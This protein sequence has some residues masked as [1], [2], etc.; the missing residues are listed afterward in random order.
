MKAW[1][2]CSGSAGRAVPICHWVIAPDDSVPNCIWTMGEADPPR[3]LKRSA[4]RAGG[5][6]RGAEVVH[7]QCM[8][9]QR[10]PVP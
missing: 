2:R 8:V 3:E 1:P 9:R 7:G 4:L 5:I 10:H 6:G